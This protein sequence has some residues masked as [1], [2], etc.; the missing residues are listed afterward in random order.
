MRYVMESVV[1]VAG[2]RPAM[3][4]G[5]ALH[6]PSSGPI[7]KHVAAV[8]HESG[9]DA[10]VAAPHIAGAVD[11]ENSGASGT[12]RYAMGVDTPVDALPDGSRSPGATPSEAFP[13]K[14]SQIVRYPT[15]DVGPTQSTFVVGV[16]QC[17]EPGTSEIALPNAAPSSGS[18]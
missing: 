14:S 9:D 3:P 16:S 10:I 13:L 7:S 12:S 1:P 2:S 11:P 17:T 8:P 4:P 18:D 6:G 15:I 5:S